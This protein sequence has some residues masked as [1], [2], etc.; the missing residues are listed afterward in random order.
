[1]SQSRLPL[2]EPLHTGSPPCWRPSTGGRRLRSVPRPHR[3]Q[4]TAWANRPLI[5]F[6]WRRKFDSR[7]AIVQLAGR[8]LRSDGCSWPEQA[9]SQIRSRSPLINTNGPPGSRPTTP[10]TTGF[11]TNRHGCKSRIYSASTAPSRSAP[12]RISRKVRPSSACCLTFSS[13]V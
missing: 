2:A 13:R 7:R 3:V 5:I 12:F 9:N 10:A 6:R 4:L 8:F 11:S 1:M